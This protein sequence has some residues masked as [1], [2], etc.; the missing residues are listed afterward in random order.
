VQ[1]PG[2]PVAYAAA[3]LV[4]ATSF[5]VAVLLATEPRP[6][7]PEG[8]LAAYAGCL[9]ALPGSPR[10]LLWPDRRAL[11]CANDRAAALAACLARDSGDACAAYLVD[12]ERDPPAVVARLGARPARPPAGEALHASAG[13]AATFL[14][15]SAAVAALAIAVRRPGR[16]RL[17]RAVEGALLGVGFA[18]IPAVFAALVAGI[19]G[20]AVGVGGEVVLGFGLVAA[21]F[22]EV[23]AVPALV[24]A[25][26]ETADASRRA[27]WALGAV[28]VGL[29]IF[30]LVVGAVPT[31]AS[32]PLQAL[33]AMALGLAGH[34][35]P[36]AKARAPVH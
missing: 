25:L 28:A 36:R 29:G 26:D 19:L 31:P 13:R 21:G 15:A 9:A 18:A 6:V 12:A 33:S 22:T 23:L 14:A 24:G 2:T 1:I 20:R 11:P 3:G 30:H 4:F 27:R 10:P 32:A 16:Q 5:A 7:D 35:A 8:A 17:R 34:F